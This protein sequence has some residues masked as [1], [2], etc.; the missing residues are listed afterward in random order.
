M[1]EFTILFFFHCVFFWF[2]CRIL[3][4]NQLVWKIFQLWQAGMFYFILFYVIFY[5][6]MFGFNFSKNKTSVT[7]LYGI[8][9]ELKLLPQDLFRMVSINKKTPFSSASLHLNSIFWIEYSWQH[10][11]RITVCYVYVQ[12]KMCLLQFRKLGCCG[13][14]FLKNNV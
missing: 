1:L 11:A 4:G 8:P 5:I 10:H 13:F 6:F 9:D 3:N 12:V 14:F 2:V 7:K